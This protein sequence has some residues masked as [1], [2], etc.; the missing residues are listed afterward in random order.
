MQISMG[1][2]LHILELIYLAMQFRHTFF[3]LFLSFFIIIISGIPWFCSY[4]DVLYVL[5]ACLL[6]PSFGH[7]EEEDV[8]EAREGKGRSRGEC[9]REGLS[10]GRVERGKVGEERIK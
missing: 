3:F 2:N 10:E 7:V 4:F 9:R 1:V 6:L 8:R 5:G